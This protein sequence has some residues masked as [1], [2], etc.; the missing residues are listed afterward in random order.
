[1]W[2]DGITRIRADKRLGMD[3]FIH[4]NFFRQ[5][6]QVALVVDPQQ[7]AAGFFVWSGDDLLEPQRPYQL[8]RV[9][10][11]EDERMK[12][13]RHRVRIKLGERIS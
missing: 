11:L 12:S 4:R 5:P 1:M 7:K 8:F 10:E 6:W 3:L 2:W 9:A 13:P